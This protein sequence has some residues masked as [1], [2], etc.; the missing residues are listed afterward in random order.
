MMTTYTLDIETDSL[1]AQRIW[2][3]CVKALYSDDYIVATKA[4]DLSFITQDDTLI[5]HNGVQF[6]I[7]ILNRLWNTGIKLHQVKDTLIMSR[8][9]YLSIER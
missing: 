5:T 2:C 3:V 1:E 8:L 6:D 4:E 9:F 7:P